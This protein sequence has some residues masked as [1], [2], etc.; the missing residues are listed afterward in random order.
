MD[1][2]VAT[3]LQ[4]LRNQLAALKQLTASEAA[5]A[6][7]ASEAAAAGTASEAAAAG[8]ASEAATT[9]TAASSKS[10][11][12]LNIRNQHF[13]V[14]QFKSNMLEHR[15]AVRRLQ[16]LRFKSLHS[17]FRMCMV[18]ETGS[19]LRIL[20]NAYSSAQVESRS[21]SYWLWVLSMGRAQTHGSQ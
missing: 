12:M 4:E 5:T 6:G 7:T 13:A 10:Q 2:L 21:V 19:I 20:E 14:Q 16:M 18:S 15:R 11:E 1:P 3:E 17:G 9:G 8:T